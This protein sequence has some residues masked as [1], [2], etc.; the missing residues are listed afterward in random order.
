MNYKQIIKNAE[1]IVKA[2]SG[3]KLEDACVSEVYCA[4]SRAVMAEI[5]ED[6]GLSRHHFCRTHAAYSITPTPN[7]QRKTHA[8]LTWVFLY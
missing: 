6:L 8:A 1:I 3:K 2:N 7:I 5:A 4:I